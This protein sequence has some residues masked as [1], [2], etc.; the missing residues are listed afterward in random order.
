MPFK[1]CSLWWPGGGGGRWE[2]QA[3][4]LDM[5]QCGGKGCV[6]LITT[7]SFISSCPAE[8][9]GITLLLLLLLDI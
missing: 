7:I 6:L 3:W 4:V 9:Q 2:V 1:P 8:P 5:V